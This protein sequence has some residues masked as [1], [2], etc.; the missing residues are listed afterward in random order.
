MPP[1]KTKKPP[2]LIQKALFIG[3]LFY[4]LFGRTPNTTYSTTTV[5][6]PKA[7]PPTKT[8]ALSP[9]QQSIE[10]AGVIEPVKTMTQIGIGIIENM[11]KEN[12]RQS[13][14]MQ[15]E[16]Q[17]AAKAKRPVNWKSLN[18]QNDMPPEE[19]PQKWSRMQIGNQYCWLHVKTLKKICQ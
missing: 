2:T 11:G 18:Y 8:K 3:V 17:A 15:E 13:K 12:V 9:A 5:T 4:V 14:A 19:H 16:I 10:N 6:A 7:Q 1:K